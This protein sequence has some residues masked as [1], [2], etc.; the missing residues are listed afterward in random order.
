MVK[1][2]IISSFNSVAAI[3]HANKVQ[4]IILINNTYQV[5]DIYIGRVQKL[6][7]SIN[8]AFVNLGE[9]GKSGFI[10]VS[11][12]KVLKK[13]PRQLYI[14]QI[15][16]INQLILVQ[17]VKEPTLNKGPRLTS[18]IH[19]HGKYISLMPLC[20]ILLV[21]NSIY[22]TNERIHL[23]ALGLLIK[24]KAMGITIKAS[25]Q[26]VAES[27][28]LEDLDF[29][30][31]QW[32]FIQKKLIKS[33]VPSVLY[34]D[35]DLAKKVVRDFYEKNVKK[36]VVDSPSI[37]ML[38]YYYLNKWSYVSLGVTTK[39]QLYNHQD[40]ILDKFRIKYSII[41]ALRPKVKLLHG[42]YLFIENYEALTVI[43]VNSG[44]FNKLY[45]SK[46]SIL[47]INFYAAV[48]IAYQLKV[49]NINGVIIIDFIDMYSQR[50]QMKLLEHFNKLLI[51]DKCS[52][53]IVQLSEL[54]LLELTRRRTNQSLQEAFGTSSVTKMKYFDFSYM[55]GSYSKIF[56]N[57]SY[58]YFKGQYSIN[59]SIRSLFFSKHF[60][61]CIVLEKKAINSF[62]TI[63]K[64][65]FSFWDNK[66]ASRFFYPKAN[67]IL[68]LSLYFR[69]TS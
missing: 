65:Y 46:E 31:R 53:Q 34:K 15:L 41:K 66:Y 59:K 55:R 28:I 50:D 52:P 62:N 18:N 51:Y 49:R 22:D 2:I 8:A 45:N 27:L 10:H 7:S 42:G 25:A 60:D 30:L 39:L 40:C 24:P 48:E 38:I 57:I 58:E 1:K 35:E 20:N 11:D 16:S 54:G 47:R 37:L 69:L 44:S 67:Y 21:S 9:F 29:L 23:H 43:D 33:A 63:H 56:F 19:L 4:Q 5:N 13:S 17:V 61:N 14:H 64:E 68:P 12:V 26:G 32:L 36:I 6:F 3:L